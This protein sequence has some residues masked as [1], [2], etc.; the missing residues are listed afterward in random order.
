MR[1][2]TSRSGLELR[3]LSLRWDS[4]DERQR[5]CE[6]ADLATLLSTGLVSTNLDHQPGM[7]CM[8]VGKQFEQ[9]LLAQ[10]TMRSSRVALEWRHAIRSSRSSKVTVVGVVHLECHDKNVVS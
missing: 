7:C 8:H 6:R 5:K 2:R 10:G 3:H 1:V 9:G 4:R